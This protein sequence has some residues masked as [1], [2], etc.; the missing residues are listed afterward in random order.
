MTTLLAAEASLHVASRT[1]RSS[2]TI[3]R[4]IVVSLFPFSSSSLLELSL[5]C[6]GP[7]EAATAREKYEHP[8]ASGRMRVSGQRTR[9]VCFV[10]S[11]KNSGWSNVMVELEVKYGPCMVNIF[12]PKRVILLKIY[13]RYVNTKQVL[14]Q[15]LQLMVQC[16]WIESLF[17]FI[18]CWL[19]PIEQSQ[20]DHL[21]WPK[22]LLGESHSGINV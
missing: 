7:C 17:S 14:V 13:Q 8:G 6:L 11:C 4:V 15:E 20:V 18:N 1:D 21:R 19:Q 12:P 2:S 22:M 3:F 10:L 9:V 5:C 16:V